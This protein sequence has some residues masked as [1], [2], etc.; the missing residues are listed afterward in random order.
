MGR[1]SQSSA[2]A[3][4]GIQ[5]SLTFSTAQLTA[6]SLESSANRSLKNYMCHSQGKYL[7]LQ[8]SDCEL[9]Q[10]SALRCILGGLLNPTVKQQSEG[11]LVHLPCSRKRI[12]GNM[13][14]CIKPVPSGWPIMIF[15][16]C[17]ACPAAPFTRLSN[18][19]WFSRSHMLLN[20]L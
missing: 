2:G 7:F 8:S 5:G 1:S 18:T 15:R 14:S 11:V 12:Y 9:L 10:S 20:S 3:I 17:I 13:A 6:G 16:F 19:A 4:L